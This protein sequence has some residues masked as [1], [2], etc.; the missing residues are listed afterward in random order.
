M[1]EPA[2]VRSPLAHARLRRVR[3]PEGSGGQVFTAADL[4]EV[5]P[6]LAVSGLPGFKV[7]EQPVLAAGKIR[8][9]G[10]A[11]AACIAAT[12]AEAEDLAGAVGRV[13][14]EQGHAPAVP[15]EAP[16]PS[17]A[18]ASRGIEASVVPARPPSAVTPAG[19]AI[20]ERLRIAR[21]REE[22]W[23]ALQDPALI[24]A[25][26]PGAR[27]DAVAAGRTSG[28]FLS[29][30]GPIRARFSGSAQVAYVPDHTG[31]VVGE[32][33]DEAS[34]M[35]FAAGPQALAED[36]PAASLL[37]LEVTYTLKGPLAQSPGD[38]SSAPSPLKFR[39]RL[40]ARWRRGSPAPPHLHAPASGAAAW[41]RLLR[42]LLAR[43][44]RSA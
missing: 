24:A 12:R 6:I 25:C 32:G 9:A 10:K 18:L 38:L 28:E 30:L 11:V 8:H 7:S 3:L 37:D 33:I 27:L 2:F 42:R 36:G 19:P 16:A 21:P 20:R 43:L 35:R 15:A 5:R 17:E 22:V 4:A 29:A 1:G 31:S 23:R 34:R 39:H 26:L 40:H 41:L 44:F 13:L 14:A